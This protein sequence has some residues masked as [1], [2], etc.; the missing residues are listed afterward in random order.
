MRKNNENVGDG[1][2]DVP[3]FK[4][5]IHR[6]HWVGVFFRYSNE[7]LIKKFPVGACLRARPKSGCSQYICHTEGDSLSVSPVLKE[8]MLAMLDE[9]YLCLSYRGEAECISGFERRH[10]CLRLDET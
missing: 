6:P 2:L 7:V 9:T 8:D 10:A 3:I 1:V 5:K 4:I